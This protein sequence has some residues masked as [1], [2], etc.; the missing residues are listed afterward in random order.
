MNYDFFY[1]LGGCR[2]ATAAS[3]WSQTEIAQYAIQTLA[4]RSRSLRLRMPS[5]LLLTR[6]LSGTSPTASTCERLYR[7]QTDEK[8]SGSPRV[9]SISTPMESII[10]DPHH[11]R[12]LPVPRPFVYLSLTPLIP[13]WARF[14]WI[15]N[16]AALCAPRASSMHMSFASGICLAVGYFGS[17]IHDCERVSFIPHI[18]F[19]AERSRTYPRY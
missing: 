13:N 17:S 5:R 14:P 6:L 16:D 2:P 12:R 11:S 10:Q 7:R 15:V 4:T 1:D 3:K 19:T 8:G 18:S 9:A